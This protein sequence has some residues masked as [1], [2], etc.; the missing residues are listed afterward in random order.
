MGCISGRLRKTDYAKLRAS[1]KLLI[2]SS[3]ILIG[4]VDDHER[5]SLLPMYHAPVLAVVRRSF[6]PTLYA[7]SGMQPLAVK[8]EAK[9]IA[10]DDITYYSPVPL[11]LHRRILDEKENAKVPRFLRKWPQ[12]FDYRY[13]IGPHVANPSPLSLRQIAK[14][15]HFT[16]YRIVGH[17]RKTVEI[18]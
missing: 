5:L 17:R 13:L 4:R 16:L 11:R 10:I 9:H 18:D 2:P 12:K 8:E 14:G 7:L 15:P 1:F 6:V 3:R